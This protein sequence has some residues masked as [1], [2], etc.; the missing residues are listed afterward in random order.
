MD[1]F[2]WFCLITIVVTAIVIA[3][4]L[5]VKNSGLYI[6]VPLWIIKVPVILM[7]LVMLFFTFVGFGRLGIIIFILLGAI[8][9]HQVKFLSNLRKT[10]LKRF[11]LFR[12]IMLLLTPFAVIVSTVVIRQ[13]VL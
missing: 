6:T 9:F 1:L 13:I 11:Q 8:V 5:L 4:H 7:N 3:V 2:F 10:D 12:D